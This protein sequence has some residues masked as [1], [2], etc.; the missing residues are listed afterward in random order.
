M[1]NYIYVSA[2]RC[3]EDNENCFEQLY[4]PDGFH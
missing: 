3:L 1:A 4:H 2:R